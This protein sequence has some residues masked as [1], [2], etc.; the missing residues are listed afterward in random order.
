M[1]VMAHVR[2]A[3]LDADRRLRHRELVSRKTP[4]VPPLPVDPLLDV[5]CAVRQQRLRSIWSVQS[6]DDFERT[7]R[8]TREFQLTPVLWG[9][10]EATRSLEEL[11][12][13]P[14]DMILQVDYGDEP[15][16]DAPASAE[17]S[18]LA[19]KD[20][21]APLRVQEA[22]RT[23]WRQRVATPA[24]LTEAGLRFA[25]SSRGVET[26]GDVLKGVR[27]AIHGGLPPDVALAALTSDAATIL[28]LGDQL[29]RV[30]VGLL[31]CLTIMTG[32][33][34]NGESKVRY[35]ILP[36]GR[37]EFHRDAAPIPA[38]PTPQA[39]LPSVAGR[40]AV[41]I[42]SSDQDL[43]CELSLEQNE[44]KLH[45]AFSSPSGNGRVTT[46]EVSD[47]GVQFT[48]SIGA[49]EKSVVLRFDGNVEG[50][51]LVGTMT[52]PFGQAAR[53]S[54]QRVP[55]EKSS[56]PLVQLGG[57]EI[58]AGSAAKPDD[59]PTELPED[60]LPRS[61]S[62]PSSTLLI[63][64]GT[65]LTGTGQTL[66]NASIWIQDGRIVGIGSE[67]DLQELIVADA[68]RP[69]EPVVIDAAG[70]YVLPGLIDTHSHIMIGSSTGL[71]G[72]NEFTDSIV[73]EVSVRD[74]VNTADPAEYRALAAGVTTARLLHGSANVI[75]GQDAIVQLKHGRTAAEHLL[76]AAPQGVK[77]ALGENVKAR[78]GRFPNTRLGVEATL[79]RA[80][81]EALEY[82]R[83]WREYQK[84]CQLAGSDAAGLPPRRDLRLEAL[85]GILDQQI[86]I[87]S[88]CYRADEILMLLRVA[89]QHGIRVRSLQHVLEGYKVAPEIVAHGASCST[90]ADWWAYK[91]EAF[92]ATPHNAALLHEAGANT[93]IKSDDHELIRHLPLEAAKTIRYGCMPPE[94]ALQ[95]VTL[96]PARELGLDDRLGSIEVGKQADLAIFNGHP[97]SPFS[98]CETTII[99][100]RVEFVRERQPT[101]MSLEAATRTATAPPL[102]LPPRTPETQAQ[103]LASSQFLTHADQPAYALVGA[104]LHP[105]DGSDV[106]NGTLL[107]ENG[108]IAAIG[109]EVPLPDACPTI[110]LDG[111]HVYP[112]LIDAGTTL[113]LV[114]IGKVRETHDFA[115][116]G[117]FQ[118]DLRAGIAINPD[119]EL[120]PVAR[121]GGIT[122]IHV[123]P[124]GGIIAGQT[125]LAQLA[126]WTV[127]ELLLV[128]SAALQV[129]W[130]TGRDRQRTIDDLRQFLKEA[131]I[132]DRVR[133]AHDKS[134]GD[135]TLPSVTVDPRY[136]ALRPFVRGEKPVHVEADAQQQILEAV[137]FAKEESLKL[138]ITGGTDAW[139]VAPLLKERGIPVIIGPTMRAPVEDYDPFDAPYANPGRLWEAGVKFCIR[140][141][142]AS[143]SRNA[144]FEAAIA[145]AYGLPEN[146]ALKAVT[147]S[148][149]EI[150]GVADRLGSLTPGKRADLIITD[151]S[152]LLITTQVRGVILAGKPYA[153][154]SRQTRLAE[155]YRQRLRS[156]RPVE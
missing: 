54:A 53:W 148:S 112:G 63:R 74:V 26:P 45:G 126:G 35:V 67:S 49:G 37:Y 117:L 138:V 25:F 97:F 41:V 88:H 109:A 107:V 80:F 82:R 136:E 108:R 87:H 32:P 69:G 3:L 89:D 90:F 128:E 145:V 100:G 24:A 114:E 66:T 11:R 52:S 7:L 137:Q 124:V 19:V 146:E 28:G 50:D 78:P 132:Y 101:A 29:G 106:P 33:L 140:S 8:F 83:Q 103:F 84:K 130:P 115:E 2:Q 21:P 51:K 102:V 143:N 1:G 121:A 95:T 18:T 110:R 22:R 92:D 60:R 36:G 73:C 9:G 62:L 125:S 71:R 104:T 85:A 156:I 44:Q 43:T 31:G 120:I 155:R 61:D 75:G 76:P 127:P 68:L 151:G 98:R 113:G 142:N 91:V 46:G 70:R 77:F 81:V 55:E 144:P 122:S 42:Q 72:V 129:N 39:P 94:A 23:E 13:S 4:D 154:E 65:I 99:A 139:K 38:R 34:E 27:Q 79:H 56:P 96:N 86:F 119:S 17:V 149:A 64:N 123:R 150:L 118:P 111:L 116:G 153:P 134:P 30:E 133:T 10:R 14:V 57:P 152:P 131:R 105:I 135:P 47:R 12:Q 5:L 93:V 147:L 40:W 16:I 58:E 48:V 20:R 141:N 59:V 6:R 15:K